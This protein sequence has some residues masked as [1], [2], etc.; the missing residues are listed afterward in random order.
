MS[1][2]INKFTHEQVWEILNSYTFTAGN[3]VKTQ[4]WYTG[5]IFNLDG[6]FENTEKSVGLHSWKFAKDRVEYFDKHGKLN[7]F[8]LFSSMKS[9]KNGIE[10]RLNFPNQSSDTY[11][12]LVSD[13]FKKEKE[14]LPTVF[15]QDKDILRY[16]SNNPIKFP[17]FYNAGKIEIDRYAKYML[18]FEVRVEDVFSFLDNDVF[19]NLLM[20]N[21]STP[22]VGISLNEERRFSMNFEN[23][24]SN[25]WKQIRKE[26][27]FDS[28]Y[29]IYG[30]YLSGKGKAEFREIE[31]HKISSLSKKRS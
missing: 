10:L 15:Y 1:H 26:L 3:K 4:E 20:I 31:L 7:Q 29:V 27:S 25:K 16:Q 14:F 19:F 28:D 17:Y 9:D 6:T 5:I 12:L 13:G 23:L 22:E 21:A 2:Q 24:T 30:P 11:N 18:S 8:S